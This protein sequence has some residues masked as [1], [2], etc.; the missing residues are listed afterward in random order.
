MTYDVAILG[1]GISGLCAAYALEQKNPALSMVLVEEK[2]RL[3]GW[4]QTAVLPSGQRYE[5]GPRSLLLRGEGA[6]AAADLIHSL[7]LEEEVLL[8]DRQAAFRYVII[9]GTPV[10]LPTGLFDMVR[11]PIGRELAK[12]IAAEPFQQR[13]T[14]ED[15]SVASF[16]TRRAPSHLV[17][18][19]ADALVSGIWGGDPA[20]LSICRTFPELKEAESAHGSCLVGGLASMFRKKKRPRI[21]GLCSFKNGLETLV[22]AIQSR[23]RTPVVLGSSVQ[24]I[25]LFS[26]PIF[27]G[28]STGSIRAKKVIVA[29]P[30]PFGRRLVPPLYGTTPSVPHAS[31][32]TIVMGW[33]ADCLERRGF[34]MLAPSSEDPYVL[35]VVLDSCVF[36][37]Q[38]T[39]MPTRM[40]VILGGTRWPSAADQPDEVLMKIASSRV[41]SWTGLGRPCTEYAIFRSSSAIPQPIVGSRPLCPYLASSCRRLFAIGPAVGGVSVKQCIAS[42]YR[43]AAE[44]DRHV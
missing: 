26:D 3:G 2:P 32:A 18:K 38:N 25:N 12:K 21:K 31:F 27:I 22:T 20:R 36:P 5:A 10:R 29:L 19:L 34:G 7:G 41:A 24:S 11:T 14:T 1:G 13:G 6:I 23:L 28:T 8:E 44:I 39:H 40:T 37:E 9:N 17:D 33:N 30:E 4:V 15:E 42:A 43:A 35:G 16:F